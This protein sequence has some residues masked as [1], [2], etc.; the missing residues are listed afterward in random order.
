MQHFEHSAA[1]RKL[2]QH[3]PKLTAWLAEYSIYTCPMGVRGIST[4]SVAPSGSNKK[5]N[6]NKGKGLNWVEGKPDRSAC[7]VLEH[8]GWLTEQHF[9]QG[10]ANEAVPIQ[11]S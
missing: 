5:P 4:L 9:P 1:Q 10:S 8:V 7:I 2:A 11:A 3:E 6:T